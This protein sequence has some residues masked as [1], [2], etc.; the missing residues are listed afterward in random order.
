MCLPEMPGILQVMLEVEHRE[1]SLGVASI[2][3]AVV[4]PMQTHI[5]RILK[6]SGT[7]IAITIQ[8]CIR[9]AVVREAEVVRI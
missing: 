5:G 7:V 8:G 6:M 4:S 2:R 9:V 3:T 1:D